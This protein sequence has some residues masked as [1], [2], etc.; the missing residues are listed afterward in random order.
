M[1]LLELEAGEEG[2]SESL[3]GVPRVTRYVSASGGR[4][5]SQA[6]C[7]HHETLFP[8]QCPRA[9]GTHGDHDI[10][11]G[12][13]P[14]EPHPPSPPPSQ[15]ASGAALSEDFLLGDASH[16]FTDA[17]GL[18]CPASP[19]LMQS[20]LSG[21]FLL[22]SESNFKMCSVQGQLE[23]PYAFEPMCF[24]G[25]LLLPSPRGRSLRDSHSH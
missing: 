6:P 11:A 14:P 18:L 3:S 1:W 20:P 10:T 24:L 8:G 4:G 5:S 23:R 22:V 25:A 7:D 16:V 19:V 2:G 12:L 17:Q 13:L 15:L 9:A 21:V